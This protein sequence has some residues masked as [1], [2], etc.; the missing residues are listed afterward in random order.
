MGSCSSRQ[1]KN[2]TITQCVG[3]GDEGKPAHKCSSGHVICDRCLNC[4]PRW[5]PSCQSCFDV[6]SACKAAQLDSERR[7]S[8][9]TEIR[10]GII[11]VRCPDCKL[12]TREHE[13]TRAICAQCHC[14]FCYVCQGK[15]EPPVYHDNYVHHGPSGCPVLEAFRDMDPEGIPEG[16]AA[17]IQLLHTT[18]ILSQMK[19]LR[20]RHPANFDQVAHATLPEEWNQQIMTQI[21]QEHLE[22]VCDIT[23]LGAATS[24]ISRGASVSA[25]NNAGD[26]LLHFAATLN[27]ADIIQSLVEIHANTEIQNRTGS[28]PLHLAATGNAVEAIEALVDVRADLEARNRFGRTPLHCAACANATAVRLRIFPSSWYA[29]IVAKNYFMGLS[30]CHALFY[31]PFTPRGGHIFK[32]NY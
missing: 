14:K 12:P 25:T 32:L 9:A 5:S 22:S 4:F 10:E 13:G 19:T 29:A 24:F 11:P 21:L 3:C 16:E 31:L 27:A 7:P 26:T 6:C 20:S 1:R 17:Q 23:T 28:T 2:I 18:R 30:G 15:F 8:L